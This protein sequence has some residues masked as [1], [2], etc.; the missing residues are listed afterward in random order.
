MMNKS[1][2]PALGIVLGAGLGAITAFILGSSGLWLAL[3][4]AIG[5]AIGGVITRDAENAREPRTT[6]N[7]RS[8]GVQSWRY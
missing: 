7:D 8:K 5:I 1:K 2:H 4:I 6:I 3:G